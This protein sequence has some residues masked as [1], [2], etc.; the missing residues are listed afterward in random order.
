[1]PLAA[2]GG[3]AGGWAGCGGGSVCA[4]RLEWVCDDG[5]ATPTPTPSVT[6]PQPRPRPQ[7][8]APQPRPRPQPHAPHGHACALSQ[9]RTRVRLCGTH[10]PALKSYT[11]TAAGCMRRARSSRCIAPLL[12]MP[13]SGGGSAPSPPA[14]ASG[15]G[16]RRAQPAVWPCRRGRSPLA[17]ACTLV[18]TLDG[19]H[20]PPAPKRHAFNRH[21]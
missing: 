4:R 13:G 16:W 19:T 8:H 10:R 17:T 14:R 1:M 12:L 7:P 15:G 2:L 20:A 5:T 6:R 11:R 3:T 9:A 21:Q 18:C